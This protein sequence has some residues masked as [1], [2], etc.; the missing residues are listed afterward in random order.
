[1]KTVF[2]FTFKVSAGIGLCRF[3]I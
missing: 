3:F 2:I 1:M